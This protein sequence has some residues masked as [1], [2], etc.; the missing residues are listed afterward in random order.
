MRL[1]P[2]RRDGRTGSGRSGSWRGRRPAGAV[3]SKDAHLTPAPARRLSGHGR[4]PCRLRG[5]LR[6]RR[7]WLRPVGAAAR[8]GARSPAG[9]AAV[10][11]A[12][13]AP[14]AAAAARL[15]HAPLAAAPHALP[16]AVRAGLRASEASAAPRAVQACAP[17]RPAHAAACAA[18]SS[19]VPAVRHAPASA[20]DGRA[21][22]V[23]RTA[24]PPAAPRPGLRGPVRRPGR[25][26]SVHAHVPDKAGWPEAAQP[27]GRQAQIRAAPAP[28][29]RRT[30]HRLPAPRQACEPSLAACAGRT[31][32]PAP[33]AAAARRV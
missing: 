20:P 15:A 17:P 30:P 18:P 9:A 23:A 27:A 21:R 12:D 31:G 13:G 28:D 33:R 2:A 29:G 5:R 7:P 25:G 16:A 11:V 6:G 19:H 32:P 4:G 22:G 8:D 3:E 26:C 10:P 14:A 1:L 24:R